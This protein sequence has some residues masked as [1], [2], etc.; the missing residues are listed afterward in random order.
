MSVSMQPTRIFDLKVTKEPAQVLAVTFPT[1]TELLDSYVALS[2]QLD[3][4][5]AEYEA[6]TNPAKA[7]GLR[8]LWVGGFS[9]YQ[10]LRTE[11]LANQT[12]GGPARRLCIANHLWS[13]PA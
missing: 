11:L 2:T 9:I 7:N 4:I 12:M 10:Q 13:S 3:R 8:L 5:C 6:E 1:S